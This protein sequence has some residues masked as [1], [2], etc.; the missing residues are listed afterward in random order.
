MPGF[1]RDETGVSAVE[2]ALIAPLL[3]MMLLMMTDF[4][5]AIQ[6]RM[7]MNHILRIGA[8]AAMRGASDA[9]IAATLQAAVDD[10]A[11]ARMST[12]TVA[13]PMRMCRCPQTGNLPVACTEDCAGGEAP[14]LFHE[15][16]ATLPYRSILMGEG[17]D[18]TLRGR[19]LVQVLPDFAT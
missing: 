19:L 7:T 18:I 6:Q 17:L 9:Q 3:V 8:E 2:F 4:G 11:T 16:S 12:L 13:P 5:M 15:F 1:L 10:H 14:D